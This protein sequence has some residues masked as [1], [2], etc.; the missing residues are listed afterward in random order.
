M[1]SGGGNRQITCLSVIK[2][3][4]EFA[5]KF[6]TV[7]SSKIDSV[8]CAFQNGNRECRDSTEE[9]NGY[10]YGVE[11]TVIQIGPRGHLWSYRGKFWSVPKNFEVTNKVRR[12]RGW[13]LW[14]QGINIPGGKKICPF[15]E[16]IFST[17]PQAVYKN[18]R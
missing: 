1:K 12:K 13:E 8:L 11:D 6:K 18:C 3:F 5:S 4:D 15:R 14:I 7:I 9:E 16:L 17:V 10:G 2:M